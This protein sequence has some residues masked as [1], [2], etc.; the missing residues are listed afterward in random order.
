MLFNS[1]R[2]GKKKDISD[3]SQRLM[4]KKNALISFS[5]QKKIKRP[6]RKQEKCKASSTSRIA[7]YLQK[8]HWF[9]PSFQKKQKIRR[10]IFNHLKFLPHLWEYLLSG[11]S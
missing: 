11:L 1:N 4:T 6:K 7:A 10:E 8:R 3:D 9:F 5:I 2:N